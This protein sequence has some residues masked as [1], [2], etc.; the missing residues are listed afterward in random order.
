MAPSENTRLRC[1]T[2][3][4]ESKLALPRQSHSASSHASKS[5]TVNYYGWRHAT[6]YFMFWAHKLSNK[7]KHTWRK[8]G[9]FDYIIASTKKIH[10]DPSLILAVAEKWGPSPRTN[11]FVFSWGEATIT[12]EDVLVLLGFFLFWVC[13]IL[14]DLRA[15]RRR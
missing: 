11:S 4:D 3:T 1:L 9:I 10:K 14:Q 5:M 15:K 7:H 8:A 2:S 6:K 12:L 13:R